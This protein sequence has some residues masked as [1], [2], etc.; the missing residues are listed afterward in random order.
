MWVKMKNK[1]RRYDINRT[2]PRH[3]YEYTKYKMC[4]SMMVICNKLK[5]I[6]LRLRQ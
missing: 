6:R 2:R 1:S 3:G 4:P 5:V